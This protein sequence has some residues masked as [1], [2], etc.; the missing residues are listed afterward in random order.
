[1]HGHTNTP[2]LPGRSTRSEYKRDAG[3][4]VRR[5][6]RPDHTP[7]NHPPY[8]K[9]LLPPIKARRGHLVGEDVG[10]GWDGLATTIQDRRPAFRSSLVEFPLTVDTTLAEERYKNRQVLQQQTSQISSYLPPS[11]D[12]RCFDFRVV[13]LFRST[14][15][16]AIIVVVTALGIYAALR[17]GGRVWIFHS[18]AMNSGSVTRVAGLRGG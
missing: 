8:A 10:P 14:K 17:M 15:I 6:A 13:G 7:H 1:M 9:Q 5:Q 18:E 16:R 4:R 11:P 3:T 2:A 12:L